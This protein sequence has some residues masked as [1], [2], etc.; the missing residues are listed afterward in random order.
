MH[1]VVVIVDA[2]IVVVILVI[3]VII[4]VVIVVGGGVSF[5][6]VL[7]MLRHAVLSVAVCK[8]MRLSVYKKYRGCSCETS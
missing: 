4:V 1:V 8:F 7:A 5:P 2:V 3:V 6:F